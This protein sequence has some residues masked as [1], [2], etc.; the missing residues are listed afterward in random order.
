MQAIPRP[1]DAVPSE[2][3]AIDERWEVAAA[4]VLPVVKSFIQR[5]MSAMS[6]IIAPADDMS[7]T[8]TV[9]LTSCQ[10]RCASR[11][12][13]ASPRSGMAWV[14]GTERL[15]QAERLDKPLADLIGDAC[16]G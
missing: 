2:R 9:V 6:E 5:L 10:F 14:V 7:P 11:A 16:R 15:P 13:T 8:G 4:L 12:V 3:N 1:N